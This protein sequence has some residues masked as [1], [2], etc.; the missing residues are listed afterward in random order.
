MGHLE[1]RKDIQRTQLI[2][3][4]RLNMYYVMFRI[5]M[6][7]TLLVSIQEIQYMDDE[8]CFNLLLANVYY[9]GF[10]HLLLL[11]IGI[12]IYPYLKPIATLQNYS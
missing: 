4:L 2:A 5:D 3:F 1:D 6:Q 12:K 11:F 9:N 10:C 7:Y 8:Y